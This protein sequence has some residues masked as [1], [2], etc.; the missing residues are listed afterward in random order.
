MRLLTIRGKNTKNHLTRK[1]AHEGTRADPTKQV[2]VQGRLMQRTKLR[3]GRGVPVVRR[4]GVVAWP[5]GCHVHSGVDRPLGHGEPLE[6]ASTEHLARLVLSVVGI[7]HGG[8][9]PSVVGSGLSGENPKFST[10]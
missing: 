9:E 1:S 6:A 10:R 7:L 4:G 3:L 2:G 8:Q 5:E